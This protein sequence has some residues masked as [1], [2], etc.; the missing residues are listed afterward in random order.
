MRDKPDFLESLIRLLREHAIRFCVIGGHAVNAYVEPVVTL[1]LDLVIAVDQLDQAEAW[2]ASH[3]QVKRF[4]HRINVSLPGSDL[5][6]QIQTDPRYA[7]FVERASEREIL[8]MVLPVASLEDTLQGKIWAA[9]D[10]RRRASQRQKDL[11]DIARLLEAYPELHE[12]VPEDIRKQL[13][14]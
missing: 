13:L 5:R 2:L 4:P 10:V 6:V 14:L 8:G 9:Q 12:R 7:G 3:F 11:A 1:D